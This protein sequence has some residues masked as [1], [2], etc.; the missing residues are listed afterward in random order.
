MNILFQKKKLART[1][2]S[3]KAMIKAFGGKR[4][5]KVRLRF[6]ELRAAITLGDL[7]PPYSRPSR[8]HELSGNRKGVFS[9]DLDYPY[10]LLF[11]PYPPR[12]G[13]AIDWGEVKT[14][15]VL[16]IEDTHD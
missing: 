8:C 6:A 11:E 3:E 15:K 5:K 14:V 4:T 13:G 2:A 7:L 10:R 12:K 9:V 1:F 16:G